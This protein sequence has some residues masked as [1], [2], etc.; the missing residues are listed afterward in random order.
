MGDKSLQRS[1]PKHYH[2]CFH[3]TGLYPGDELIEDNPFEGVELANLKTIMDQIYAD[4]L[5]RSMFPV[6]MILQS[7]Q[8][9]LI[10]LIQTGGRRSE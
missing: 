1:S 7:V 10:H 4:A 5:W 6:M 8:A 3:K 9:R 2:K